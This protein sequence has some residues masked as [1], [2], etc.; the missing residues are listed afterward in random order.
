MQTISD[1]D[2][3]G[4]RVLIRVDF[5]VPLDE[6]GE[7]TDDLRIR[8]VL[9]TIEYALKQRAKIILCSHMGRPKGKRIAKYSLAPVGRYLSD[10]LGQEVPLI[11]SCVGISTESRVAA[12]E[13]GDVVLLE[14]LRYHCEEQGSDP[15]FAKQLADLADVYINDAFAVCHRTH[16]SVVGVTE[17]VNNK[18]MG[19]LLEKELAYFQR[20]VENP[21]R[22]LIALVGGA[23][24]S[25]KLGALVNML[26]KVDSLI[27]GGAMANTFLK[28]QGYNTG[29]SLVENDLLQEAN[30]LLQRARQKGVKVYLPVDLIVAEEPSAAKVLKPV[31][32]QDIPEDCMAL[33][34]GPA[35]VIYFQEVLASAQTIVWNGP[36]GMFELEPY[37]QG[38]KDIAHYIGASRALTITGGGDSNAAVRKFGE[39]DNISYMSTG[40]GAFLCLMEGRELPGAV[41]LQ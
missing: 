2:I 12:M 13:A 10:I 19:F 17:H 28:S 26:D 4:K 41:A 22:P 29:K 14:N 6:K 21:A 7:I 36:M 18:G 5:N 1:I 31:T 25:S 27:I 16:A 32:V 23:K 38:T 24:V 8:T 9:P 15:E 11:P 3:T 39:A 30:E 37:A 20:L 34:I 35:S 33:D 40:G